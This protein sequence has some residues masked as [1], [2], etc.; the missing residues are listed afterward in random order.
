MK[1]HSG[2][3]YTSVQCADVPGVL[4]AKAEKRRLIF[5][6]RRKV[7]ITQKKKSPF[8]RMMDW[9]ARACKKVPEPLKIFLTLI[10]I[11]VILSSLFS[12]LNITVVNPSKGEVLSSRNLLSAAGI[13]WFLKNLVTNFTGYAALGPSLV[14]A[15]ATGIADETGL[16]SSV[17][18]H[19][20]SGAPARLIPWI[21]CFISTMSNACGLS[22][23]Y[24]LAPLIGL[25]Y[26]AIGK[27]PMLGMLVVYLGSSTLCANFLITSSD[28][29]ITGITNQAIQASGL[30]IPQLPGTCNW[31]FSIACT[32][33]LTVTIYFITEKVLSR[34]VPGMDPESLAAFQLS[35][36][37]QETELEKKGLKSAGIS[38]GCYLIFLVICVLSG[39][40]IDAEGNNLLWDGIVAII[41]VAFIVPALSYGITV[42][43]IKGL[44][45]IN[46][47]GIAS[48]KI[49]APFIMTSFI[50]SQFI[51]LLQFSGLMNMA[52][53]VCVNFLKKINIS[54]G[55]ILIF[56][57]LMAVLNVFCTSS[58]SK[59]NVFAPLCIPVFHELGW[60]PSFVQMAFRIADSAT[61]PASPITPTLYYLSDLCRENYKVKDSNP[62]TFL[63]ALIP[64][65]I[66]CF[67]VLAVF[68]FVW[69]LSGLPLGPV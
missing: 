19:S 63:A 50:A 58:T 31:Y 41:F 15:I 20:I 21:C 12:V 8:D 30:N 4:F 67:V 51:A 29:V 62:G 54:F 33:V 53:V 65:S 46:K 45:D 40:F 59:W 16:T 2:H 39:A 3:N 66:I 52:V 14:M 9:I 27:S 60:E 28:V 69:Y 23:M 26:I 1:K 5:K 17:V 48:I 57:I 18:R 56:M 10:F 47:M 36:S 64:S 43:K 37:E 6:E 22:I 44:Q 49:M 68:F 24:V 38:L 42:K 25:A 11:T 35:Q 32:L 55:L 34:T 7:N 13:Q 61:N